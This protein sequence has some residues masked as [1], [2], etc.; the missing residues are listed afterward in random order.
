M[1]SF[2]KRGGYFWLVTKVTLWFLGF[3]LKILK[4][5]MVTINKVT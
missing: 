3:Y 5:G 1:I 2:Y 4:S